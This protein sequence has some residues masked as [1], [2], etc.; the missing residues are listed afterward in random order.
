[1]A[2][3]GGKAPV[4]VASPAHQTCAAIV[5]STGER[6][7]ANAKAN[8]YCGRHANYEVNHK[9]DGEKS[10]AKEKLTSAHGPVLVPS[11]P[12]PA[13]PRLPVQP[14]PAVVAVPVAS[15]RV[16]PATRSTGGNSSDAGQQQ[17]QQAK[18]KRN[19][20]AAI[21]SA[22]NA[23]VAA[24]FGK[25]KRKAASGGNASTAPSTVTV[26]QLPQMMPQPQQPQAQL[27][28]QIVAAPAPVLS[29]DARYMFATNP[30]SMSR[31]SLSAYADLDG[32]YITF[33]CTRL[34][35]TY[36]AERAFAA[37]GSAD[38]YTR[39]SG[40]EVLEKDD[41]GHAP[42]TD[43]SWELQLVA[44]VMARCE[45][46]VGAHWSAHALQT[47]VDIFNDERLNCVLTTYKVNRGKAKLFSHYLKQH[48]CRAGS[49]AQ[50]MS[51]RAVL[52]DWSEKST[53]EDKAVL[54]PH[55][56]AIA[57]TMLLLLRGLCEALIAAGERAKASNNPAE[58]PA[59]LLF[60]ALCEELC[61]V[62]RLMEL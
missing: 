14:A 22:A 2:S 13:Q 19:F 41:A 26:V 28:L 48:L 20:A 54:L 59:V 39:R 51:L 55:I 38:P 5:Q 1:M 34:R 32:K 6:C 30:A 31:Q 43:H 42:E 29:R 45:L 37:R 33:L 17:P 52:I 24:F 15:V 35:D 23:A 61:N 53:H 46:A 21:S 7:T 57:Q 4:N 16:A 58:Q 49:A 62:A 3:P 50:V 25:P 47:C 9:A 10:A 11:Q 44:T 12:V 18:K 40:R 8:G 36:N 60:A 56:D 27:P